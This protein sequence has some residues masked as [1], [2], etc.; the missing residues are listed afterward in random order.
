MNDLIIY[1]TYPARETFDVDGSAEKLCKAI[2]ERAVYFE[3]SQDLQNYLN[4]N[5]SS[6]N[7]LLILGAG[8]V[9]DIVKGF[10]SN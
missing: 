4:K 3:S 2:G 6:E 9:Y 8:D 10:V 1:K 5:V 7:L